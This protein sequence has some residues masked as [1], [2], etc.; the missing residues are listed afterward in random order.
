MRHRFLL[1]TKLLSDTAQI[2]QFKSNSVMVSET[3]TKDNIAHTATILVVEDDE[4]TV[5]LMHAML[6]GRYTVIHAQSADEGRKRLEDSHIDIMLVDISLLGG[7]N[8]L[9]FTKSIRSG[10]HYKHLPII[11]VTAHA[12]MRDKKNALDAGCD[13]YF[14]KPVNHKQLIRKI[15]ELLSKTVQQPV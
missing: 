10:A 2:L 3:L 15:E 12:Y 8:G 7:E 14:A 9:D 6:G 5:D 1:L 13:Y 4:L 11:A